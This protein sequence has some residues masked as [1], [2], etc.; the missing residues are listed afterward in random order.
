VHYLETGNLDALLYNARGV[1]TVN[2]TVGALSLQ[3]R[4][5]TITLSNPIY[6]LPGLT[7]QGPLNAFW[8]NAVVP[9]FEL[10]RRFRNTVIR[11]TQINGGFY[12][13]EGISMAVDNSVRVLESDRSPLEEL[14]GVSDYNEHETQS[15]DSPDHGRLGGNRKRTGGNLR[16]PRYNA[17]FARP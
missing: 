3:R 5:P 6:N 15:E 10:F 12:S 7:F 16:F 17:D 9:D 2:S 8:Q 1:V 4:C 11:A 13:R 14:L